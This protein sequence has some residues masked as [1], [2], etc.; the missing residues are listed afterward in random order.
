MPNIENV[1]SHA[2]GMLLTSIYLLEDVSTTGNSHQII[3][4]SIPS[5][6]VSA[7]IL[8]TIL[9]VGCYFSFYYTLD[10]GRFW[11]HAVVYMIQDFGK[12]FLMEGVA[13]KLHNFV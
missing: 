8:Q 13:C 1:K 7:H 12:K 11:L 3:I 10:Q 5:A 2:L 9:G 6:R 4:I